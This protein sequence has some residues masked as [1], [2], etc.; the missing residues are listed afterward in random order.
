VSLSQV[1]GCLSCQHGI[2]WERLL[3]HLAG[4]VVEAAEL[5]GSLCLWARA[6]ADQAVC[7]GCGYPSGRVHSMYQ[8]RLA[9]APVG[10]RPVLI[11]LAV[12]RFFCGNPDCPA[13]TFAE[14]IDGL[15]SRRA[16]RTPPLARALTGIALALAG[17][18]GA[19][20]AV[21]LGL[22]AGRTGMLRLVMALPDPG[23][24]P[25]RVLGVD[26]FAFRRGRDYGTVLVNAETGEPVE[27]LRDREAETLEEWLRGHP[28]TEVICR[29]RAGAYADGARKGA[30]GAV[31]VADRWHLYHN[32]AQHVEKA[33]ARHAGCLKEPGQPQEQPA[34]GRQ[35]AAVAAAEQRAADSAL[36]RRTRERYEQVQALRG[37]GKGIKPVMRET[38]LAKE[39]VRRY[40]RAGSAGELLTKIK[41]GRPSLLDEHKPYL[42][43]R[44]NEGCT[45]VRQLHAELRDRGYHGSYSTVREYVQPFREL[46]AAPPPAPVPPKTR[47]VASW[48]LRAPDA[49]D[50]NQ[51]AKLAQTRERCPHLDA[52]AGHVTEFAKIL[53]GL[54]GDRLGD[55]ITAVE[56]DDQPDLHSFARGLK[57]DHDAVLNGLTM[58]W[59]SGV[60]EGNVNRLKMIKRQ[61]YG[62][63]TFA[64]L[65]KRVLLTT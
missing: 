41:G 33:V 1:S 44:W 42:H 23:S 31:Q 16:R 15:T 21:M 38:G 24:G 46:R 45:S 30:P 36:A 60:V 50:D 20:L 52:L 4:V 9:D 12:R 34:G 64:L 29:D 6:R 61:M 62:R 53:T 58:P 39:T 56:A 32:L 59:S 37:Q 57:H 49:L 8:R 2:S 19:R 43:Q 55:W 22:A 26:D 54:H 3:P 27:L 14:Q 7:P 13:V 35:Q 63:A 48:I 18:A 25:V 10:G 11:R 28:G 17:R 47:E 5:A 40:W 65:R 51:K